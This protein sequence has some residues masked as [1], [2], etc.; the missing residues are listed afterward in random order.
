MMSIS[1]NLKKAKKAGS[2]AVSVFRRRVDIMAK[3]WYHFGIDNRG[4]AE[5]SIFFDGENRPL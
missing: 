2:L 4:L 5:N 1:A 3:K